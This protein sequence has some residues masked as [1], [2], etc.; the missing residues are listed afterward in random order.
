MDEKTGAGWEAVAFVPSGCSNKIPNATQTLLPEQLETE[1]S[2]NSM[3]S[4]DPFPG[5]QMA[6]SSCVLTWRPRISF[7]CVL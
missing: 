7:G 5:S 2:V 6:I 1:M 4:G 3:A